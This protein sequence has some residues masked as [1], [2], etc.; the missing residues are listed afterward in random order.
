M[1]HIFHLE[2]VPD[3]VTSTTSGVETSTQLSQELSSRRVLALLERVM[4][5]TMMVVEGQVKLPFL[6]GRRRWKFY[7]LVGLDEISCFEMVAVQVTCYFF[8]IVLIFIKN[9]I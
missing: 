3:L 1:S 6:Q 8:V 4:Q 9:Y 5:L 2:I 7:H